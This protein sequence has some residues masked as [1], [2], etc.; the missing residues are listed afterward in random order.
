MM[1]QVMDQNGADMRSMNMSADARWNSLLKAD[2]ADLP[3]LQGAE[4]S[5]VL[6][7]QSAA[8]LTSSSPLLAAK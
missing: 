6:A 1:S 5:A 4:L 2:L 8:A 3:A 7:P